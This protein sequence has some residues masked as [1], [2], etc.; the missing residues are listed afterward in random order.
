MRACYL[1]LL[2]GCSFGL[3]VIVH[4]AEVRAPKALPPAAMNLDP[5]G[6]AIPA[7]P[8]TESA[9]PTPVALWPEGAPGFEA[10][11]QEPEHVS[12][13]QEKDIVFPVI[14]NVHHPSLTPYLPSAAKATGAAVIIAPGGGNWFLTIDR[15]GYDLAQ[16]L[17]GR[18]IAAFVLKYRL[19]RDLSNPAGQP[20]PYTAEHAAA[21]ASRAIRLVRARAAEW[22]LKP[23]RI[24]I[25]GF[26]AGGALALA[27]AMHHDGGRQGAAD[28][29][30]RQSSRPDF[31]APIYTGGF[32]RYE[33]E[34]DKEK[35]PPAFLACAFDDS[36]PEAMATF[37]AAL[38]KAG[39]N[40]ELHIYSRG[41]HGF[42][43]RQRPLAVTGW[44]TRFVEWLDDR[45]FLQ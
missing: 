45:G 16:Q 6:P 36:M 26:S 37:F 25:L 15:E 9:H 30:E 4:A 35:V 42:G 28:P 10:R 8:P 41:G 27:A 7:A 33:A 39:V 17:A 38:R 14:S 24:G 12:Y 40:A 2:A 3:V 1:V 34:I 44:S 32:A 11:Q 22:N 18:G 43:V 23:D 21:D 29:V 20:Q 31:F 5:A 19:A 13:R